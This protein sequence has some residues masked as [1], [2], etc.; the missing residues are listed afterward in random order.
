MVILQDVKNKPL[1]PLA[2]LTEKVGAL[3]ATVGK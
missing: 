1:D 2:A 3:L